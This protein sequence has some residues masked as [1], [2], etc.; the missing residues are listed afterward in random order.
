MQK[1]NFKSAVLFPFSLGSLGKNS[2]TELAPELIAKKISAEKTFEVAVWPSDYEKSQ[3]NLYI[4]S[5]SALSEL[6]KEEKCLFLGGDHS[7]S[8]AAFRAFAKR[9]G[10]KSR[11]VLIDAHLDLM[12]FAPQSQ[13]HEDWLRKLVEEK[14]LPPKNIFI[15]GVRRTWK[16]EREYAKNKKIKFAAAKEVHNNL[17]AVLAALKKFCSEAGALYLSI[18]I[19]AIDPSIAPATAYREKNGLT[20]WQA[21]KIIRVLG[22]G[23]KLRAIDLVEANPKMKGWKKTLGSALQILKAVNQ[24]I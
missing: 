24:K 16:A 4:A 6:K 1:N 2:G 5:A 7:M 18:D 15:L 20:L 8:Y 3:G 22:A 23:G 11:L 19:D 17:D 9:F 21:E 12:P 14:I 10:K 13:S